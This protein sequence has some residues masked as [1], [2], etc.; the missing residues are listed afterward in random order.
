MITYQTLSENPSWYYIGEDEIFSPAIPR[1]SGWK[2]HIYGNELSDSVFIANALMP[3]L[4]KRKVPMKVACDL[5]LKHVIGVETH[6]QYG[7]CA[8]IY[9]TPA[10]FQGNNLH[11]FLEEVKE[12]L[13]NYPKTGKIK[14]DKS[15]NGVM[16]Y[17]YELDAPID[18]KEGVDEMN[19]ILHYRSAMDNYNIPE[20]NEIEHL[21]TTSFITDTAPRA[22]EI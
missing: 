14:G 22:E 8:A 20:N 3:I 17:R 10:L 13:K 18:P 1:L 21:W 19:Y 9:L 6:K 5:N 2:F 7:K 12:A 4:N 11:L 15:I 16:H